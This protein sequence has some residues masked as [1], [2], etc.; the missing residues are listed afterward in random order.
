MVKNQKNQG[1]LGPHK[2]AILRGN[3][4]GIVRVLESAIAVV[5]LLGFITVVLSKQVQQPDSADTVYK[6]Q[7]QALREVADNY[8]L[9]TQIMNGYL[10]DTYDYIEKRLKPFPVTFA[11]AS[12]NPK[13]SCHYEGLPPDKDIY[14]D[15]IIISTN[16]SYYNETKLAIFSWL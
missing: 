14:A 15:E 10:N 6:I 8:T 2:I 5:I 7:H 16:L 11:I 1:F 3:K 12:C 4:K 13:E 9:R